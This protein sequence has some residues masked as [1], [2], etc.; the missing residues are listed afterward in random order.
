M[1]EPTEALE[2]KDPPELD[3]YQR[4]RGPLRWPDPALRDG[5][6]T[7]DA[8]TESDLPSIVLASDDPESTR[9]LE[10]PS[11]YLEEHAREFFLRQLSWADSGGS[12][13]F[14]I[15]EQATGRFLGTIGAHFARSRAGEAEIGYAIVPAFRRQGVAR[16][17]TVLLARYLF[18]TYR[19]GRIE[20][21]IQP[22]N[23]ASR[24]AAEG[25]GAQFEG[26]RRAALAYAGRPVDA[27]V[28]SLLP[29]DVVV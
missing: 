9:W 6:I 21:L 8:L 27:A 15:R 19:P 5:V 11:P 13:V 16:R 10:L 7:L 2:P 24:R 4:P 23:V 25:A 26:I 20:L 12:L 22:G 3:D 17:A 18:A 1:S 29:E 28:Y 14:A